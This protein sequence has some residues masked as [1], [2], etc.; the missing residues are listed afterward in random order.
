MTFWEM[1]GY[2]LLV[3]G[4]M[5]FVSNLLTF[6][7]LKWLIGILVMPVFIFLGFVVLALSG[8]PE[9]SSTEITWYVYGIPILAALVL[10]GRVFEFYRRPR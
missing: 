1:L 6:N 3:A 4:P 2:F 5:S 9:P 8:S 7:P 10:V